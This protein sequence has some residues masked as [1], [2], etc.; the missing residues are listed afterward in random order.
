M[1]VE[2]AKDAVK[3]NCR[4]VGTLR[5]SE[6]SDDFVA[7]VP[8]YVDLGGGELA[9]F[10]RSPFRGNMGRALD[11]TVWLPKRPRRVVLAA[12]REVL[13]RD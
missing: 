6:V 2:K 8:V 1:K 9:Q 5:Q 12:R 3:N 11:V 10:G 7:L 13:A 4:L